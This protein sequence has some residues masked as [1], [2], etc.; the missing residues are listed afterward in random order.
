MTGP[1]ESIRPEEL[2]ADMRW[3]QLFAARLVSD[4]QDLADVTQEAWAAA[5]EKA[6]PGIDRRGL[7]A[8]LA[9]VVRHRVFRGWRDESLRRHHESRGARAEGVRDTRSD[10]ERLQVQHRLAGILLELDEPYRGAVVLRY[11]HDLS[12]EEIG[13][14]LGVDPAAARKRVSRGL[15]RLRAQLERELGG[16]DAWRSLLSAFAGLAPYETRHAG[17]TRI[18]PWVT[19]IGLLLGAWFL[20]PRGHAPNEVVWGRASFPGRPRERTATVAER[21][22]LAGFA[23]YIGRWDPP[24][25][26]PGESV[27]FSWAVPAKAVL[28]RQYAPGSAR[29]LSEGLIG[30]H[31]GQGQMV[32]HEFHRE[33]PEAEFQFEGSAWFEQGE[34]CRDSLAHEPDGTS[35]SWREQW[36]LRGTERVRRI[37]YMDDTGSWRAFAEASMRRTE[38]G[39]SGK[40]R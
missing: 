33:L 27:E 29:A 1:I 17:P 7:R 20:A 36:K 16:G 5:L 10:L 22:A 39:A 6:P 18:L 13:A 21:E 12:Y 26:S 38:P 40:E 4:D 11:Y 30:W 24:Q 14:R 37:E 34:L 23:D 31:P 3:L 25:G 28:V 9:R 35:R 2:L 19:V 8:W 32:Y 15:A